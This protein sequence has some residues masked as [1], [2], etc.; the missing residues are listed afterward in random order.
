VGLAVNFLAQ[1]SLVFVLWAKKAE[2]KAK[3]AEAELQMEA[4]T[5]VE[6][7]RLKVEGRNA[8]SAK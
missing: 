8:C 1:L 4:Q 7:V 3:K 6:V 2:A 5:K